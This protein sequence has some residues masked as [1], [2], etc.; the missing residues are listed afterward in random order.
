MHTHLKGIVGFNLLLLFYIQRKRD[1]LNMSIFFYHLTFQ[2]QK[3]E[4]RSMIIKK[5][6]CNAAFTIK[7]F[8]SHC[9]QSNKN[10]CIYCKNNDI[11][12]FYQLGFLFVCSKD[13]LPLV[14][15]SSK[16]LQLNSLQFPGIVTLLFQDRLLSQLIDK[17]LKQ[18]QRRRQS[19]SRFLPCII[20]T[21]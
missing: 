17:H 21:W 5:W 16:Q 15:D 4:K 8:S 7:Y 13:V 1:S 11:I 6:P 20:S 18:T 3:K 12:S 19:R 9:Q 14:H 2:P 10:V